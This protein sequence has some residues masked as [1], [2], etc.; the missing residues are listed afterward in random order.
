MIEQANHYATGELRLQDGSIADPLFTAASWVAQLYERTELVKD[1]QLRSQICDTA[2]D[3]TKILVSQ[4]VTEA[5]NDSATLAAGIKKFIRYVKEEAVESTAVDSN[6]HGELYKA[7]DEGFDIAIRGA[8]K[9]TGYQQIREDF[10]RDMTQLLGRSSS[11]DSD[12]H[13]QYVPKG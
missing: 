12:I 7:I 3:M 9:V 6:L 13:S 4:F 8:A 2:R 1:S 11:P 5:I 10:A